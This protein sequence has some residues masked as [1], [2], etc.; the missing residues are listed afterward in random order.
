MNRETQAHAPPP[1]PETR[2]PAEWEPHEA[3]WLA[4]PYS[5][6]DWPGKL[7]AVHWA[8]VEMCR[9]IAVGER[10]RLWMPNATAEA[11]ARRMFDA[12]GVPADAIEYVA[13]ATDRTWTRDMGPIFLRRDGGGLA[14]ADFHFNGWARYRKWRRDRGCAV[15]AAGRLG[16]PLINVTHR[17]R[18]VVL[19]GGAI[20]VNGHGAVVTTEECL[21]DSGPQ[22]RNP[23]FSRADYEQ[24]FSDRLGAAR[25]WWLGRGI[26][27]DDTH[28]HVDDIARFVNPRTLVLVEA[29]PKDDNHAALKE[30]FERAQDFRLE[31]GGKPEIVPLPLPEPLFFRGQR[32][33]ASYAN[34]TIANA[35]VL[36]PTFNDPSDRIALGRLGE[37]FKDRPVIGIHAVDLVLGLGGPHCLTHEQPA[38]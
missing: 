28:G 15:Q 19:E 37:L 32:L 31:D 33:P 13:Y 16:L 5:S 34:F 38:R 36:V 20:D 29:P 11:R 24:V 12:A 21:L 1:E 9:R 8:Y 27:G 17:G 26:L 18:P 7:G 25:T 4:W 6:I 22:C 35:A 2:H 30:N 14:V 3:T 23:G 10:V